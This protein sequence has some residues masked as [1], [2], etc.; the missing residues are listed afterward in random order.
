MLI[1]INDIVEGLHFFGDCFLYW[2]CYRGTVGTSKNLNTFFKIM[3]ITV[4]LTIVTVDL[5]LVQLSIWR[6]C[7]HRIEACS[8]DNSTLAQPSNQGLCDRQIDAWASVDSTL[9]QSSTRHLLKKSLF[10]FILETKTANININYFWKTTF[11]I[12][13]FNTLHLVFLQI[14]QRWWFGKAKSGF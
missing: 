5:T 4:D 10:C 3:N 6:L 14:Q 8:T 12:I 2:A 13:L 1:K 7:N 11:R 9:V